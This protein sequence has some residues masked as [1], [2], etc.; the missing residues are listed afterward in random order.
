MENSFSEIPFLKLLN[1]F[2]EIASLQLVHDDMSA[3]H[4]TITITR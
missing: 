1:S 3:N 4:V 2:S